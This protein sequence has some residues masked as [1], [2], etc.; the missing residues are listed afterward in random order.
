MHIADYLAPRST[1][2]HDQ[3]TER[4]HD[5]AEEVSQVVEHLFRGF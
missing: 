5:A 4:K 3:M 2:A 1:A